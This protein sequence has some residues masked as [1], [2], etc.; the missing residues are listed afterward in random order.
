MMGCSYFGMTQ[1]LAAEQQPPSL[2]AI[3]PYDAMTDLYRDCFLPGGL[4]ND[5]W[6]RIWFSD[7]QFLNFTGG[8]N[9][10]TAAMQRQFETI[11]GVEHPLDGEFF[12]ERSAWP[13]LDKIT[14]PAYWGCHWSFYELH[15]RGAFDAWEHA[16]NSPHRRMLLG[17][18]PMPRRP[19]AN[20]HLEAL[21]WYDHWL[22]GL[23]SG[24]LEGAP[25]KLW[26]EGEDVWREEQEWPLA[27]TQWTAFYLGGS[28]GNG[29]LTDTP[30]DDGEQT[31]DY[32]PASDRWVYGEPRW[33]YRTEPLERPTEV[34]GP[35]QLNLTMASS[36][37]DTDW[38]V[39]LFDEA[40]DGSKREVTRGYLRS[41][42]RAVDPARSRKY[43]PWH[44]HNR[45]EPLTP[46]RAEELQI[47][48][49]GNCHYF[50]QGHRI[51]LELSN[52][53]DIV[54]KLMTKRTLLI[55][56]RNTVVQGRGKSHLV[57]PIIP[58]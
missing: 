13:N 19:Y 4:V 25:I 9:P 55:P 37:E 22:K 11:L 45:V 35:I 54:S 30:P 6:A 24:V 58:R 32:N 34:T 41:S 43:A 38:V 52:C 31:L 48:L 47:E 14:V 51:R 33:V 40:P 57:L 7:V 8:R 3:F 5:G 15:L 16:V 2:K 50:G 1:N 28:P 36:A 26:I 23:D 12:W 20:Y 29:M 21:R 56:A 49:V 10:N 42:H 44:P 39:M 27:R 17:P 18:D 46:N 53:D